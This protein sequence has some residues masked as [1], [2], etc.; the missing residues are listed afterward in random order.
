MS[1]VKGLEGRYVN[2]IPSIKNKFSEWDKVAFD[3]LVNAEGKIIRENINEN[4][5]TTIN[6]EII[7]QAEEFSKHILFNTVSIN[8]NLNNQ[9]TIWIEFFK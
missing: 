2:F 6:S 1:I 5:S 3:I 9:G 4:M 7:S 8:T